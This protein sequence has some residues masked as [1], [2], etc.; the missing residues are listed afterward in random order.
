MLGFTYLICDLRPALVESMGRKPV[1]PTSCANDSP[2]PNGFWWDLLQE[3]EQILESYR[4]T[5]L[6]AHR[7]NKRS[8]CSKQK[9]IHLQALLPMRARARLTCSPSP[10]R[11]EKT[12]SL[13]KS[14]IPGRNVGSKRGLTFEFNGQRGVLQIGH[15]RNTKTQIPDERYLHQITR[16]WKNA[17]PSEKRRKS[18]NHVGCACYRS[19][20]FSAASR[21]TKKPEV[22]SST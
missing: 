22:A 4:N 6:G 7:S 9:H 20:S 3:Y 10:K 2:A 11:T 14:A 12:F 17:H 13:C 15:E 19:Q 21:Q 16:V 18:V 1:C 8:K 5:I